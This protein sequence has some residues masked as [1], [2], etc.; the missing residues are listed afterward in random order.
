MSLFSSLSLHIL[1]L[2]LF[3]SRFNVMIKLSRK[4]HLFIH[5]TLYLRLFRLIWH[6]FKPFSNSLALSCSAT[7]ALDRFQNA[8]KCSLLIII[9][10][11]SVIFAIDF[12]PLFW[13]FSVAQER[14]VR[15]SEQKKVV[16]KIGCVL[17]AFS[18]LVLCLFI[19]KLLGIRKKIT[20]S[21][22]LVLC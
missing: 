14:A 20:S 1:L 21:L 9:L 18:W 5:D 8:P 7:F 12:F 19:K 11:F 22:S 3:P 2:L 4:S 13:H 6:S 16:Y 10:Y 15:R 17:T